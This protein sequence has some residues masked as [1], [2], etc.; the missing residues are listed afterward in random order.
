[1]KNRKGKNTWEGE[2]G[3]IGKGVREEW[4]VR[5]RMKYERK[6]KMRDT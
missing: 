2:R 5:S 1:M 6:G 4:K 3:D